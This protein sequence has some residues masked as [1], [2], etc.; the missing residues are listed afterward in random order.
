M[1]QKIPEIQPGYA[2]ALNLPVHRTVKKARRRGT[3][4]HKIPRP[5]QG[6]RE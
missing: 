4:R 5:H 2:P 6:G 3:A 1:Y